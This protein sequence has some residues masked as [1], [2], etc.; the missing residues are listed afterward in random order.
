MKKNTISVITASFN[1]I[2]NG[3]EKFFRQMVE[4]VQQQTYQQVEHL[5]IDGGSNDGTLALLEDLATQGKIKYIS[6]PDKGIYDAMNKGAKLA[7]GEFITF[8]NSDDFF[9]NPQGLEEAVK[10]FDK[11]FDYSY[12]PIVVLDEESGRQSAGR[13]KWL[14]LLR[15][16][17]FP[18]PGMLVRKSVFEKLG[19]F[20]SSFKL[21][22]DYD[23]ILRL[24][25]SGYE[26]AE[27]KSFV[28][29]RAGGATDVYASRH[30]DEMARV[31]VKNYA[32]LGGVR[33]DECF[34]IAED[35][36]FPS[37]LLKVLR[38]TKYQL[39]VRIS[40]IWLCFNSWKRR[41]KRT[42]QVSDD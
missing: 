19:G 35:Y 29:F 9:N 21:V 1:L 24:L 27:S 4:S 22:G 40:A 15:N 31:Y 28:T 37:K 39:R 12:A 10:V 30:K 26:G 13:I 14:R 25:L 5:V 33:E 42:R 32:G 34:Q 2:A 8:L 3:R 7:S 23:F 17:P 11:G 6:E 20:D 18:H 38:G 41:I 16:M 36:I